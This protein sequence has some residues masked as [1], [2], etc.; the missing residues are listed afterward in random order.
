MVALPEYEKSVIDLV[1]Q[2]SH[3]LGFEKMDVMDQALFLLAFIEFQVLATPRSVV[4]NEVIE[5]A[6]RYS[7]PGAPKLLNGVLEKILSE[8]VKKAE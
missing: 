1:N 3:T 4:I 6:K 8:E 2:H 7:D 5:L